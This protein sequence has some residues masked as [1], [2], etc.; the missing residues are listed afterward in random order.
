MVR[1]DPNP[2]WQRVVLIGVL[3]FLEA[4]LIPLYDVLKAGR[5]P[6]S[7]EIAAFICLGLIQVVTFF[8]AFLRRQGE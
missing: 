2:G 5:W 3:I 1:F 7:V 4:L 8:I 6:T